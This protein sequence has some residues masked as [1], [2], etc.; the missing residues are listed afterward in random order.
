MFQSH[1]EYEETNF[2]NISLNNAYHIANLDPAGLNSPNLQNSMWYTPGISK[3][4]EL[5]EI[6]L[7]IYE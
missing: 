3:E 2:Y 7:S 1:D 6:G 4:E 5:S